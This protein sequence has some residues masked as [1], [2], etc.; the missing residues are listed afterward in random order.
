MAK[1]LIVA[2]HPDDETLGCGGTILKHKAAGDQVY[3]LIVTSMNIEHGFSEQAV[4]KRKMEIKQVAEIYGFDK[5]EQFGIPTATLDKI[6]IHDLV[7]KFSGVI[8]EFKPN[9]VYLPFKGDIHSDHRIV[10]EAAY[11]CTKSFRYPY[12]KKLLMM[13]TI[14]ETEFAS[15]IKEDAFVP[16]VFVDITDFF[17]K[18]VEIM[19]LYKGEMGKHPFPRSEDNFNALATFRGAMAGCRYAESFALLKEIV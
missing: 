1:I 13:E 6:H 12:I 5:V 18:K 14:S 19:R 9:I 10:F 11:S 17:D 3:W 8:K 4:I 16:N 7:S 2:T 15:S